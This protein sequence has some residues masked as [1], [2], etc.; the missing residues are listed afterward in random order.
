[1]KRNAVIAA[2]FLL[3]V[4]TLSACAGKEGGSQTEREFPAF[5]DE[6]GKSFAELKSEHPGGVLAV[7]TDG[8]PDSAAVCFAV[9]GTEYFPCF[10][11]AQSGDAERAVNELEDRLKCAGFITTAGVLFPEMEEDMPFEDF[12][13]LIG[14]DEYEYL[15]GEEVISGEGWLCF[16][17]NGMAVLVNTNEIN[18][19]GGWNFTGTES[20]KR[21]APTS[22]VDTE[23]FSANQ[24]LA[25]SVMFD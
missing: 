6:F 17:Y 12:F 25:E 23:I 8:F 14:V 2:M 21:S 22:V 20:V 9:S 13:S 24:D 16:T 15:A 3:A 10:F 7:I 11:G 5:F 19:K 18:A 4:F 1:M